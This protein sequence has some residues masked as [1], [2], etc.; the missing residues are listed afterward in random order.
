MTIFGMW[1]LW[2][3]A[4]RKIC[5]PRRATGSFKLRRAGTATAIECFVMTSA[6]SGESSGCDSERGAAAHATC[7]GGQF[8]VG[9]SCEVIPMSSRK[10][11]IVCCS[12]VGWVA[13]HLNRPITVFCF[14]MSQT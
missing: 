12:A 13:F 5:S 11:S 8:S 10:A 1:Q 3:G 2:Q 4:V 6:L 7:S 9:K 14:L